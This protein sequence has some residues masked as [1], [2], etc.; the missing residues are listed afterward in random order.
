[1]DHGILFKKLQKIGIRGTELK[2]F[3]SYLTNRKQFVFMN[4]VSSSLLEIILGV[5]QGSILGPLLFLI[6]IN[7][8]PASSLLRSLLFADDTALLARGSNIDELAVFVNSEFQKIVHYFS[9]NKLSLHPQKTKVMFFTN[10]PAVKSNPPLIYANYNMLN[11]AEKPELIV[12]IE[13]ISQNSTIPAIRYLGVHFDPQL[14]FKYHIQTMVNK[15]SKMLYFY[16]QA[17]NVLTWKAKK[18]LYYATI[19]S[20]LIFGIHIWSCTA[21]SALHPLIVKQKMSIRI[22][23]NAAYNAHTEPLFKAG[24]ILPL[25]SLCEFFKLQFMQKFSQGFL[26]SSF[27]DTWVSNKIRRAGQNQIE[28]RNNDD[29]N[30]PFARLS[31]TLRHPLCSFPKIWDSFENEQIKFT[32]NIIEFNKV[33]KNHFLSLLSSTP[34]CNRLLCP[35]CHLKNFNINS[36]NQDLDRLNAV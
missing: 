16:R 3:K 24:D 4:G 26:P 22:L 31:S 21:E 11:S 14:N 6:Y 34:T 18:T 17:K 20:N 13:N 1:V 28:L 29:L 35:E 33:L 15:I 27:D 10:S 9:A 23:F 12:P 36:R 7:D 8:L 5:P 25:N 30:I 2:W 32:R 19:H